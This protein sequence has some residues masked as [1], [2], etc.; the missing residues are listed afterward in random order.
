M[1]IDPG[2]IF[3][4][5]RQIQAG[6]ETEPGVVRLMVPAAQAERALGMLAAVPLFLIL[7]TIAYI[8]VQFASN[9]SAAQQWVAHTYQVI[10]SLRQV[11]GDAQDAETVTPA[12][13]T[14][15]HDAAADRS[16]EHPPRFV[17]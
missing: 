12:G 11:L 10:A 7:A 4:G 17:I 2:D 13:Q 1:L 6:I 3:V 15:P 16:C 8:T 5:V 14:A 9:E